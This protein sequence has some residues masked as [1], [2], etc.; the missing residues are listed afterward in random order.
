[1]RV[2]IPGVHMPRGP[3]EGCSEKVY[4]FNL[5]RNIFSFAPH[6]WPPEWRYRGTYSTFLA[7]AQ[8]LY[9]L[10]AD[11]SVN[12]YFAKVN[13]LNKMYSKF[14]S[15]IPNMNH[16]AWIRIFVILANAAGFATCQIEHFNS[17]FSKFVTFS[18]WTPCTR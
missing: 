18:S 5:M 15:A 9:V 7:T 8:H 10:C 4:I 11:Y 13:L 3:R 17:E 1:M 14:L 2:Y 6:Y 12:N 16:F